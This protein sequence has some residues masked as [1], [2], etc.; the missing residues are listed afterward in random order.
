ME[1]LNLIIKENKDYATF[2]HF[3]DD[4]FNFDE[5]DFLKK[6]II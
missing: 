2:F 5:K 3:I 6:K 4:I 1:Y